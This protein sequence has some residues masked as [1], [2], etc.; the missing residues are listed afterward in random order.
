MHEL[1]SITSLAPA[2]GNNHGFEVA[3]PTPI[4]GKAIFL[5]LPITEG[6]RY[7][8]EPAELHSERSLILRDKMWVTR[9]AARFIAFHESGTQVDFTIRIS[10][11][12]A[13][14]SSACSNVEWTTSAQRTDEREPLK[15]RFTLLRRLLR[16]T[17]EQRLRIRCRQTERQIGVILRSR[18]EAVP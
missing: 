15:D 5:R 1:L 9:G 4:H 6:W 17:S 16:D 14:A 2:A 3:I 7:E 11:W 18:S 13:R 8:V 10:P 12:K